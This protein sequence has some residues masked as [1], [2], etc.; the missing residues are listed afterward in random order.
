MRKRRGAGRLHGEMQV[1]EHSLRD[2]SATPPRPRRAAQRARARPPRFAQ[3]SERRV[4]V[5]LNADQKHVAC[6]V[7]YCERPAVVR[8]ARGNARAPNTPRHASSNAIAQP[9]EAGTGTCAVASPALPL[10]SN[11]PMSA[12]APTTRANPGPRWSEASSD[13][14]FPASIAMLSRRSACVRV[15]PPLYASGR[16]PGLPSRGVGRHRDHRVGR[17]DEIVRAGES[18]SARAASHVGPSAACC[19]RRSCCE[20]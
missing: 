6:K 7:N 8:D 15:G 5:A 12:A 2:W 1:A 16:S 11:A 17:P 3:S 4:R 14:L 9:D 13:A 20:R 10:N 18:P 19:R